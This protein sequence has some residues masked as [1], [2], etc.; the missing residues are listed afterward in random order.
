MIGEFIMI[1]NVLS[2]FDG[3]SCARVALDKQNIKYEKYY[4]SEIDKYCMKI[5][6]EHFPDNIN[7]G[8]IT[9]LDMEKLKEMD[10][11]LIIGGSP[12]QGFSF[13][14]NQLNFNHPKSKLFFDFASIVEECKPRYFLLE[15][16]YM[17]QEYQDIIS[18]I[19]G[20]KPILINSNLLSAQNRKRLYWTNMP[21]VK[22]PVDKGILIDTILQDISQIDE[23]YRCKPHQQLHYSKCRI[24]VQGTGFEV[25][26]YYNE[27]IKFGKSNTLTP[28]ASRCDKSATN[29]IKQ[30]GILRRLTPIE[31]ERLQNLPDGYT[32]SV[33]DTQRYKALGNGFTVDIIAHILSSA[34]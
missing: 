12:C 33:S 3:I 15:N 17:K 27:S 8:D 7:L 30:E 6:N 19:L 25:I 18:D 10:L 14:G 4:A 16:V 23:K 2:L 22:Q 34:P 5:S 11:D 13:I 9:K 20:V 31:C 26:D 29:I 32:N 28:H 21:N 1:R 24:T